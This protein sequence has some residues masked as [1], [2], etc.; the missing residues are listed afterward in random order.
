MGEIRHLTLQP[1]VLSLVDLHLAEVGR[2]GVLNT[3][4]ADPAPQVD[5]SARGNLSRLLKALEGEAV[6]ALH[7]K[8]QAIGR[9][10]RARHPVL[11]Q[12]SICDVNNGCVKTESLRGLEEGRHGL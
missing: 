8:P 3:G 6:R 1:A 11:H 5:G 9:K 2:S 4:L 7:I 12:L 10:P